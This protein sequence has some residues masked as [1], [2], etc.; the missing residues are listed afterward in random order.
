VLDLAASLALPKKCL[1]L[2]DYPFRNTNRLDNV[3][4]KFQA[5]ISI[6]NYQCPSCRCMLD[7]GQLFWII[8]GISRADD[9]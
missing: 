1:Y 9:E 7:F 8:M 5:E 6:L 4:G 3:T 2:S